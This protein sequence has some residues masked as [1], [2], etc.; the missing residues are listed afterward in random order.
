MTLSVPLG[1]QELGIA[2]V[3]LG[4]SALVGLLAGLSAKPR[5]SYHAAALLYLSGVV[6]L[7]G[8]A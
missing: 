7:I 8:A 5:P 3:M 4:T 6:L 1:A 2:V